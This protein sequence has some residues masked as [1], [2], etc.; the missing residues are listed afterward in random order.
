MSRRGWLLFVAMGVIWGLPYLLIRISVRELSPATLVFA[1]TGAAALLLLPFAIGRDAIRPLAKKWLVIVIYTV[2][3]VGI[4]WFLLSTAEEHLSSS[5]SGL[6]IA[7]VPLI[8]AVVAF[9]TGSA[10]Q[11]SLRGVAGLLFGLAG[12]AVLVGLNVRGSS[13]VGVGEILIC[14]IG[15][16]TGPAIISRYLSDLPPLGVVTASFVLTALAYS[17]YALTHLPHHM[18]GEI[19]LSVALLA[20]VCTALAFMVFFALI[21][22]VGPVK[23]TVITYVNPAV[24]VV[25]GVS[26]LNEPFTWGIAVGFPLILVGSFLTTRSSRIRRE[27]DAVPLESGVLAADGPV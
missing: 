12:V 27:P 18:T 22:E 9:A 3:E 19:W 21:A 5:V 7:S 13:L 1:R 15:Y 11:L 24:A 10:H 16:A 26:L 6:L 23:A 20:T 2:I 4:P 25:L 17:P 14:A 8:G